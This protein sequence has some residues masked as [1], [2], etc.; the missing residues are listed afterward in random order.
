MSARGKREL[1]GKAH[2]RRAAE[3]ARRRRARRAAIRPATGAA[4]AIALS[5]AGV[6]P[7][8]AADEPD[9]ADRH[10]SRAEQAEPTA[11]A[12]ALGTDV[13]GT[14]FF[15]YVDDGSTQLWKS[16]GTAAGTV[17]CLLYTSDAADE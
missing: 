5:I 1:Q 11:N 2:L 16:D 13:N 8:R 15:E 4:A 17:L 3:K 6:G 10:G 12:A 9:P 14:L 7:A